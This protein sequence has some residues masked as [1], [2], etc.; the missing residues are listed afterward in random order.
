MRSLSELNKISTV[1]DE[2]GIKVDQRQVEQRLAD[3]VRT[4]DTSTGGTDLNMKM[5]KGLTT[6]LIKNVF[7]NNSSDNIEVSMGLPKSIQAFGISVEEYH[8]L[9]RSVF[10]SLKGMS[11]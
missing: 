1:Q 3:L 11:D 10:T 4:F 9:T 7:P 6:L 8:Y 2:N 5:W